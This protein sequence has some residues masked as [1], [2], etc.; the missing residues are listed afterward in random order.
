RRDLRRLE[1]AALFGVLGATILLQQLTSLTGLSAPWLPVVGSVL[2]VAQPYLLLRLV[3]HFRPL[4]TKQH[5]LGLGLLLASWAA[6]LLGGRPLPPWATLVV[7]IAFVYVEIYA[8]VAFVRGAL[9]SRGVGRRRLV[10][11]ALGSGLLGATVLLLSVP[12]AF[13]AATELAGVVSQLTALGSAAAYYVGFAPP[14]WLLRAWQ[15]SELRR[16][17]LAVGGRSAEERLTAALENVGR[18][19]SSAFAAKAVV[20]ALAQPDGSD[21]RIHFDAGN[22]AALRTVRLFS[23]PVGPDAPVLGRAWEQQRALAADDPRV[24]GRALSRLAAAFGGAS[25]ALVAPLAVGD[26]RYGLLIALL[27]RGSLFVDD[28]VALLALL[29][30]QAALALEGSQLYVELRQRA[31]ERAELVARL[32]EQNAALEEAT[33]LKSEFLARMSHELR[34][35]LNAIIGFSELMLDTPEEEDDRPTRLAYLGTV[36]RSGKHLL[37]LINDVL[38]LAKIEAG[39]MELRPESVDVAELVRG[40]LATVEP[41]AARKSIALSASL[42]GAGTLRADAGKLRQILLNLLSNAIKFTP[43]GGRVEVVTRRSDGELELV[44]V[45]SG[46]GI[47][48]EDQARVFDEFQQVD[49]GVSRRHEGTGLGLALSRRLAELHG[50]RIWVESAPGRGSAFHVALP[51]PA[52]RD[53]AEP[54]R[55]EAST[56]PPEAAADDRRPILVVEDDSTSRG[57]LCLY[58]ARG[59]YRTETAADGAEAI[60][61]A[62]A[63]RPIA[64]TLDILLPGIDGWEVLRALK[65]DER[66]CDIPVVIASIV[67]DEPLGYALGATDYFVKPIDRHALLARLGRFALGAPPRALLVDDDPDALSLLGAMLSPAGFRVSTAAGGAE[68]IALARRERPD[69]VLLDLM[70][71]EVSGFDVVEAMRGD[72]LTREIPILVVTARDLSPAEKDWLNGKVAGV[73]QKGGFGAVELLDWLRKHAATADRG[74]EVVHARP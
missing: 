60:A 28:E 27:E 30:E 41:L 69:V 62:L 46:I 14:R 45:D 70:M 7:V 1:V 6:L 68:G 40:A 72:P 31:A 39:R 53:G 67:D 32:R 19:A 9:V 22:E 61:K 13:P 47:A 35:P 48:P 64:I 4:P 52:E 73:F 55:P 17:L 66:T 20:V 56:A 71:P 25:C 12:A 16:F 11:V 24:W 5:A 44:V 29:A 10:A 50:G 15:M 33:R 42:D 74:G 23:L 57:L 3:A 18:A 51:P 26:Q 37:D 43:D 21:L 36:H 34:T 65:S 58:L 38:D 54:V 8:T 2:G 59:G 49:S 63:L